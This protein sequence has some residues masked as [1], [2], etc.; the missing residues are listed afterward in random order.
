MSQP[1]LWA[2]GGSLVRVG[3]RLYPAASFVR[4]ADAGRLPPESSSPVSLF[5]PLFTAEQVQR[6][7]ARVSQ[8]VTAYMRI[9]A[10]PVLAGR[11]AAQEFVAGHAPAATASA[12]PASSRAKSLSVASATVKGPS[13]SQTGS[14]DVD[15]PE[16]LNGFAER[17]RENGEA[18]VSLREL[19]GWFDAK[20][21]GS[22]VM[23]RVTAALERRPWD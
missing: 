9:L 10:E 12:S 17:V 6:E 11:A 4:D 13:P 19:L 23:E 16:A 1:A 21:R 2:H 22:R 15:V 14:D 18:D 7:P 20:R 3:G 5:S 8:M